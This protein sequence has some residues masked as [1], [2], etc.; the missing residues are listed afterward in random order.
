ICIYDENHNIEEKY[1]E[2]IELAAEIKDA[3]L[4]NR[5]VCYYQPLLNIENGEIYSYESLVS[6]I[7]KKGNL[8]SPLKFLKF[9]K[10][11]RLYSSITKK[12]V[13]EACK[14]FQD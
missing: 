13:E 10:K 8:I 12:V 6:M 14:T 2:N 11:I 3:I 9:S 5:I 4:E 1:K 7:D